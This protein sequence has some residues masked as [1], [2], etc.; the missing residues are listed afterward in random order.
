VKLSQ[1]LATMA[2]VV[3]NVARAGELGAD[4]CVLDRQRFLNEARKLAASKPGARLDEAALVVSWHDEAFGQVTVG[5]GGCAHFG[6]SVSASMAAAT[7]LAEQ[8][9]RRFASRLVLRFWPKAYAGTVAA[10]LR[11]GAAEKQQRGSETSY[12]FKLPGFDDVVLTVRHERGRA[13]FDIAAE[14]TT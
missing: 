13:N 6:L 7:P 12:R 14:V 3:A 9:Q 5:I 11:S 2:L 1:I 8:E 10:T 4:D